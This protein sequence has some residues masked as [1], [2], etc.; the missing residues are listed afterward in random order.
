[1]TKRLIALAIAG[2]CVTGGAWGESAQMRGKF[3]A[4]VREADLLENVVVD[5]FN[6]RDARQFETALEQA[7][8]VP[9]GRPDGVLTGGVTTGVEDSKYQGNEERCVEW[10]DGKRDGTCLKR[11]KVDIPCF[12]R[13][14]NLTVSIRLARV[15]DNMPLW[16]DNKPLRD[17]TTWCEGKAPYRTTE[18]AVSAMI[19]DLA[20]KIRLDVR[21]RM[22]TYKVRFR[23][24]RD[25]MP[26][27][28]GAEFKAIVKLSN[29]DL[30]TACRQWAALNGRLPNH[31]SILYDLGV[32][33]EA[34]GGYA[35]AQNFY[36]SAQAA[37]PKKSSEMADSA[38]R[39]AR[40]MIAR[41]DDEEIA[42][43]A[44]NRR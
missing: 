44:A 42:R 34:A 21:P 13:V 9:A 29:R 31:P 18:E 11:A 1:M 23:E 16:S 30:P 37:L 35:D 19:Q 14:I 6:G 7:I 2:L 10:K 25:G 22:E 36:R 33:A 8:G 26:K 24:D 32:C 38:D 20:Q 27:D 15:A 41:A 12:R 39:V 4:N 40:L 5:R 28:I 17:E 43:R 3:P